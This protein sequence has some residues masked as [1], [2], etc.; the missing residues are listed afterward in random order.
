[1]GAKLCYRL[2]YKHDSNV[3]EDLESRVYSEALEEALERLGWAVV[4]VNED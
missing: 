3:F 4:E 2:V 1:M